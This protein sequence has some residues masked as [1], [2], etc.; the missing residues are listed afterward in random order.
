V[1]ASEENSLRGTEEVSMIQRSLFDALQTDKNQSEKLM[2]IVEQS[3][4][5]IGLK[6]FSFLI[7][8]EGSHVRDA[9]SGNGKHFSS[10]WL[11]TLLNRDNRFASEFINYLCDL[12]GKEHPKERKQL[13]P[14]EK[15]KRYAAIIEKHKLQDLFME[16]SK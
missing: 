9:I 1:N 8:K 5:R 11:I 7:S 2:E 6:E 15:L 16:A 12:T 3:V 13:P 4:H 10:T 14:E